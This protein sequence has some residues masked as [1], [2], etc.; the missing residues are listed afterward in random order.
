[1][2]DRSCLDFARVLISSSI[3]K[4]QDCELK[5]RIDD[6]VMGVSVH[7]ESYCRY[8]KQPNHIFEESGYISHSCSRNGNH[9]SND[10]SFDTMVKE[11]EDLGEVADAEEHVVEGA[12]CLV[13][14][15]L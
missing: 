14:L 10:M 9:V 12:P 15:D 7:M 4:I 6:T 2:R 8:H 11:T 1:M 5:L 13:N 3:Y